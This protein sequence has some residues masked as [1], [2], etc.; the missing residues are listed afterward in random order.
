MSAHAGAVLQGA[1][2][3]QALAGAV[4][5]ALGAAQPDDGGPG[6]P[7]NALQAAAPRIQD[8]LA[9]SRHGRPR[10]E[11]RLDVATLP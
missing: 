11:Y 4:N 9:R 5:S 8:L 7:A 10:A 2:L 1:M 3:L 6:A